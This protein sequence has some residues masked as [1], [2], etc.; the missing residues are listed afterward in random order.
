MTGKKSIILLGPSAYLN[1]L[2]EYGRIHSYIC[3]LTMMEKSN[4]VAQLIIM[5]AMH[6]MI[7]RCPNRGRQ[8]SSLTATLA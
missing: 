2:S 8:H 5:S 4:N 7:S 1:M 3:S 6:D